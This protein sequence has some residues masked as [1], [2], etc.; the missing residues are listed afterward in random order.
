M[1]FFGSAGVLVVTHGIFLLQ[2]VDPQVVARGLSCSW[3]LT[4]FTR[5]QICIQ[6]TA[7]QIFNHWT[8]REVPGKPLLTTPSLPS[9][10]LCEIYSLVL[11]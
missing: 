2:H 1:Y 7:R 8:R 10:L 9:M 11:A 3:D 5:D 4:S 6:C